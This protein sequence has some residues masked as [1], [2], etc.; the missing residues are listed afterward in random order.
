LPLVVAFAFI[1]YIQVYG[2]PTIMIQA[3]SKEY[4][5]NL[6]I[7]LALTVHLFYVWKF[8]AL[9]FHRINEPDIISAM[10]KTAGPYIFSCASLQTG[11]I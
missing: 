6:L 5:D 7:M 8:E 11:L 1:I 10:C 3:I 9:K 4:A 2:V